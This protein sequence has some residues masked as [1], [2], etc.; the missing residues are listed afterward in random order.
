MVSGAVA[1]TGNSVAE[2]EER[3]AKLS[4]LLGMAI[5]ALTRHIVEGG[6]A[7]DGG[8]WERSHRGG[9][10]PPIDWHEGKLVLSTPILS[11]CTQDIIK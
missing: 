1:M 11:Q 6:G 8:V 5:L 7:G 2:R 3:V 4:R 10:S 9:V